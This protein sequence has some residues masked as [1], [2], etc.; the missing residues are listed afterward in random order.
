MN[1]ATHLS[2]LNLDC[3]TVIASFTRQLEALG[4]RVVRSFDLQS[5]YASLPIMICPHHGDSPC[6]CQM[7]VLL[8]YGIEANPTSVVIHSH[9]K[10]TDIE[11]VETP[12]N[13]PDQNL[14]ETIRTAFEVIGVRECLPQP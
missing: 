5:A 8:I 1:Q 4:M 2:T 14:A 6:D 11:L 7:V 3:E 10:N 13:R 9:H 12:D